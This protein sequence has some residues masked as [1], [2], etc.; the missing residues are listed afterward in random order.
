MY[1]E[2]TIKLIQTELNK[3]FQTTLVVDGVIGNKTLEA[4]LRVPQL[5]TDWPEQRKIIGF[6][7]YLCLMEGI[8]AGP[9]D[10]YWGP[11]T[12]F[13]YNQLK[14]KLS[15]GANPPPWRDDEGTGGKI[16]A[17]TW[18]LQIQQ[19][20][21]KFYGDVGTN[22]V[23]FVCPY[24]VRIAWQLDTVITSFSVHKKVEPSLRKILVKV[25]DIY[26]MQKISQ[27]GLD[28]WGGCLNVRKMRGGTN[29][30]THAWG[31]AIDWDPARNPLRAGRTRANF[32][33]PEYEAWWKCWED[34]GWVSLGR[35]R[36]YDY[37]H[38]QAARI[39]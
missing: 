9:I 37:M 12:E 28:L 26:G 10:G 24:P 3:R 16:D 34:E 23:K 31:I 7:Q 39:A 8:D 36:N 38:V 27:L 11:Q 29:W 6:I 22:Q 15:T 21:L 20:M 19:H 14:V 2:S 33:K 1:T 4:L 32:A 25:K 17:S 18:P 5:P 35:Q 13:G 30:S